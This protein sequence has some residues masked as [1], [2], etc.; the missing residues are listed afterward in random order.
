MLEDVHL[1]EVLVRDQGGES[2]VDSLGPCSPS[3][4][5]PVAP[6]SWPSRAV[7]GDA[8]A[9]THAAGLQELW[10]PL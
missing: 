5:A 1:H 6:I 4:P 10:R 8:R 2:W 7:G 3:S 9:V